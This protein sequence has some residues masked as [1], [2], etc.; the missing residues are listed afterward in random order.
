MKHGLP[1]VDRRSVLQFE[2]SHAGAGDI[3]E[4]EGH[5]DSGEEEEGQ[6]EEST[7]QVGDMLGRGCYKGDHKSEDED[8]NLKGQSQDQV[9]G[10][11]LEN[12]VEL[13]TER[14]RMAY[15]FQTRGL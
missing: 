2:S 7:S 4:P 3:R 11:A 1:E 12:P 15:R 10:D 13:E 14:G 6:D 8:K 9:Q 5:D